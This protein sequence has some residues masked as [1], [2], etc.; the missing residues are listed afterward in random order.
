MTDQSLHVFLFEACRNG[1]LDELKR[2]REEHGKELLTTVD[3]KYRRTCLF[4]ACSIHSGGQLEVVKYLCEEI[5]KEEILAKADC[6]LSLGEACCSGYLHVVRFLSETFG[7]EM[8]MKTSERGYTCLFIACAGHEEQLD[9]VK[10]LS[11][12]YGKELVLMT[13]SEGTSCLDLALKKGH[14]RVVK[15][16]S[17]TYGDEL[18]ANTDK[19]LRK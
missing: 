2:L 9:V 5:G 17:E 12:T 18:V 14:A 11:E 19:D 6:V 8:V 13:T 7:R 10:Y 3:K 16:L 15:Y 4:Q 1:D